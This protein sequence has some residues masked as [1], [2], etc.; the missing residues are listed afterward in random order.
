VGL[1]KKRGLDL[2]GG[3]RNNNTVILINHP[4]NLVIMLFIKCLLHVIIALGAKSG[5]YIY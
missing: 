3:G 5:G 4:M 2:W 1:I